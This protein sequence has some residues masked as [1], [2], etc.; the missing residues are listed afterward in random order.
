MR[1][2]VA[3][4]SWPPEG[5]GL[6]WGARGHLWANCLQ[7]TAKLKPRSASTKSRAKAGTPSCARPRRDVGAAADVCDVYQLLR[8]MPHPPEAEALEHVERLGGRGAFDEGV[9]L[10]SPLASPFK[11]QLHAL[12]YA[13]KHVSAQNSAPGNAPEAAEVCAELKH[14]EPGPCMKAPAHDVNL[15]RPKPSQEWSA[16]PQIQRPPETYARAWPWRCASPMR[17]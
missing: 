8:G 2:N 3:M 13:T 1:T 9:Y 14:D 12:A 10:A 15:L 16:T 11:A 4:P 7:A 17:S 5:D 6:G